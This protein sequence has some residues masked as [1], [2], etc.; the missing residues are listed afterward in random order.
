[1]MLNT[2]DLWIM[3]GDF[4]YVMNTEE[5]I[6]SD[7]REMEMRDTLICMQ[8]FAMTDIKSSGNFFTWNNKNQGNA[9]VFSKLDRVL[10]NPS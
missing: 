2:A 9:R 5:R 6:G 7:V 8:H 1:M 10:D 4:N 3:C